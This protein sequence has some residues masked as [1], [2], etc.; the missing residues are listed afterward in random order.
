MSTFIRLTARPLP[1]TIPAMAT[2]TVIGCRKAKMIGLRFI[3][4]RCVLM[5][6]AD[7]LTL[8]RLYAGFHGFQCQY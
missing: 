7:R 1:T 4:D 6:I 2:M 8:H 5:F 3:L